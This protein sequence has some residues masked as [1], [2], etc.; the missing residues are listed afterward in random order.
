ML[1][2]VLKR[3]DTVP[4]MI[5]ESEPRMAQYDGP[6]LLNDFIKSKALTRSRAADQLGIWPSALT[7]YLNRKQRPRDDIRER[8]EKWTGGAVPCGSWRKLRELRGIDGVVPESLVESKSKP[9]A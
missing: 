3:L 6:R 4:G 5:H 2:N 8:I 9:A 1:V 7:Q